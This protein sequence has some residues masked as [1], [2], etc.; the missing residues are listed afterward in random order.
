MKEAEK[1]PKQKK[2]I[3]IC[4]VTYNR[5]I[6]LKDV[7]LTITEMKNRDFFDVY[8]Y[9]SSSNEETKIEMAGIIGQEE[10]FFYI[11][12]PDTTHSSKKLYDIYQD[13]FIQDSYEYL[14]ITPDYFCL[15]ENVLKKILLLLDNKWD[16]IMLDFYDRKER[17]NKSY[18]R[19]NEI[20]NEYA[21]SLTQ[22]GIILLN[23]ETILKNL[24]WNEMERKYLVEQYQNFSHVIMYF[25]VMLKIP[26]LK[27]FHLSISPNEVYTSPHKKGSSYFSEY[28]HIWGHCWY[29][30]IHALPKEYTNKDK[31]IKDAC[32]NTD[33][34]G[35]KNL[36]QLR[37]NG[38]LTKEEFHKYKNIWPIIST[39]DPIKVWCILYA[40]ITVIKMIAEYGSLK[41]WFLYSIFMIRLK[42][43]CNKYEKIFMYGAG[44]QA[45][46]YADI[47]EKNKIHFEG[48]VVTDSKKNMSTLKNHQV[49]EVSQLEVRGIEGIILALNKKNRKEVIPI[50]HNRGFS[51]LFK[52]N[53]L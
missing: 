41:N 28:L 47:L 17:G 38:V 46:K 22:Y 40:P 18:S 51:K 2:K 4:I 53:I 21:W 26:D 43:F 44:V 45:Q 14:W 19:P 52:S 8:I 34:L 30:S 1:S 48:F 25:L 37:V 29:E 23:C 11:K 50:L 27:F 7:C 3:G 35:F 5:A 13:K 31:V 42:K 9:D 32:I 49:F 15:K 33:N 20:F 12:L 36:I 24:D 10:N 16:M 6:V 39:V